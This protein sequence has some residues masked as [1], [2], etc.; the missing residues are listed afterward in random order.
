[1]HRPSDG[2]RGEGRKPI[3]TIPAGHPFHR[4]HPRD[5]PLW[6][7]LIY[8][9]ALIKTCACSSQL[10]KV[11]IIFSLSI[12]LFLITNIITIVVHFTL[13]NADA[14]NEISLKNARKAAYLYAGAIDITFGLIFFN[15]L[16]WLPYFQSKGRDGCKQ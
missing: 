8:A 1:M 2:W 10:K 4:V 15:I 14:N 13:L 5:A 9:I 3:A 6:F 7:G 11:G 12:F 16:I